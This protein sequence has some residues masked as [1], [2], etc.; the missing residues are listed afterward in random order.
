MMPMATAEDFLIS[1]AIIPQEEAVS[2]VRW[3]PLRSPRSA[4]SSSTTTSSLPST[5]LVA[6]QADATVRLFTPSGDLVLTF[7]AGHE[8]PVVHLAVSQSSDEYLIATGDGDGV[9][10]VHKVTVRQRR[11]TKDQKQARRNSTEDKVSQ[12]L[13]SST[14]VTMQLYRQ[15][16]VPSGS[17]GESPRMTA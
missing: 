15:M 16:Q 4:S 1:K 6:V 3:L 8:H 10:R 14:N 9:I 13:G 5:L 2:F 12:Y 17:D 11:L 7:S